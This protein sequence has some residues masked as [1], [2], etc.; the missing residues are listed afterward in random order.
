MNTSTQR[1]LL[2]TVFDESDRLS[3]LVENLLRMT[4]V[5]STQF[6]VE[7]QWHPVEFSRI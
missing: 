7:K 3:R 5:T 6:F 4:Q 2:Q 1:E